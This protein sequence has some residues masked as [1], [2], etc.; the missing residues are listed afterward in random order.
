M[1]TALA[2]LLSQVPLS[3]VSVIVAIELHL[4]R[5]NLEKI[6]KWYNHEDAIIKSTKV[7]RK[8]FHKTNKKSALWIIN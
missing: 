1:D 7:K 2:V 5:K 8:S 3:I 6:L 4:L